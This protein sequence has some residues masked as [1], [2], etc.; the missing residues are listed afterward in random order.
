[1]LELTGPDVKADRAR[2]AESELW[3]RIRLL[4]DGERRHERREADKNRA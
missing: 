2:C 3:R 4:R 1:M